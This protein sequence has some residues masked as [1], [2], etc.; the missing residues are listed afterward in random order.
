MAC[1]APVGVYFY[2]QNRRLYS[3]QLW[4]KTILNFVFWIPFFVQ[5]ILKSRIANNFSKINFNSKINLNAKNDNRTPLAQ[6]E[7]ENFLSKNDLKISVYEFREVCERFAG[8]TNACS[9]NKNKPSNQEKE[10]FRIADFRSKELSARC[11]HRRNQK[12]LCFHQT[13]AEKDFLQM[14]IAISDSVDEHT[15]LR[16]LTVK[17]VKLLNNSRAEKTLTEM[18]DAKLQKTQNISVTDLEKD[19]WMPET[20]KPQPVNRISMRLQT[21]NKRARWF[22]KD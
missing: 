12:R 3:K 19:L 9:N 1:G 13:E 6:K 21:I 14:I 11:L 2:F 15:E 18:F 20:L 5:I 4:L 16:R 17:F 22:A 7:I 8:L 10:F